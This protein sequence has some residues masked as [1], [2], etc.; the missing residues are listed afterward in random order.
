MSEAKQIL[1]KITSSVRHK[2]WYMMD[3]GDKNSY[4]R[5]MLC[6]VFVGERE[7]KGTV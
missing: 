3:C 2:G 1:T 7:T 4:D 5:E 6:Y